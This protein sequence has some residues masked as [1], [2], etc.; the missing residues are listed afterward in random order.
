[1]TTEEVANQL[2]ALCRQGKIEEA[3]K[4]LFAEDAESIEPDESMGAKVVKGLD[5]ILE[6]NKMF[7]SMLEE[8]HGSTISD[9]VVGGHYFSLSW[10]LDAKMKGAER[11]MMEEVC[12]YKVKDGKI[13][14][15]QFFF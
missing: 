7:S 11:R 15:E 6:K 5:G 9:P 12:V 13:A 1:M 3:Q 8:Y 4:E 2:V 10:S 14:S